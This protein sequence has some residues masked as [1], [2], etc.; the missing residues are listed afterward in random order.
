M[1][2]LIGTPYEVCPFNV[3]SFFTGPSQVGRFSAELA[4]A[5]YVCMDGNIPEET[6]KFILTH[7][8]GNKVPG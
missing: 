1:L 8:S 2:W 5:S 3:I 7:C 6:M 4:S